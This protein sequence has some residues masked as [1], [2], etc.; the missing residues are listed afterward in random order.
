MAGKS[1][2]RPESREELRSKNKARKAQ[3]VADQAA[4]KRASAMAVVH[5]KHK[6]VFERVTRGMRGDQA[7]V[8]EAVRSAPT[9][10]RAALINQHGYT[11]AEAD[12]V[13][14]FASAQRSLAKA[15]AAKANR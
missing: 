12:V 3:E 10:S 9:M 1:E 15:N 7:A 5:E 8:P 14:G 6:A 11:E 13:R 2:E 4:E